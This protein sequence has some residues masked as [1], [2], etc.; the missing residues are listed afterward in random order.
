M[1]PKPRFQKKDIVD[2]AF[3]VVR[4]N[5]WNGLSSRTIAAVLNSS[6]QPVYSY[7]RSMG[8]LEEKIVKRVMDRLFAF[9]MAERTNDRWLDLQVGYVLFARDEKHLFRCV[10]DEKHMPLRNRYY[11]QHLTTCVRHLSDLPEF[12]D[13][14]AGQIRKIMSTMGIY[15]HGLAVLVNNAAEAQFSETDIAGLLRE[16]G[17]VIH[18]G[19]FDTFTL[20]N[21]RKKKALQR[22]AQVQRQ[23]YFWLRPDGNRIKTV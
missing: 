1:P 9:M 5:G 14:T 16:A 3:T 13:L 10:N 6:T 19:F 12:K 15:S 11:D 23:I 21:K 7:V 17:R 22:K 18:K 20:E 4:Q 2:A 8:E